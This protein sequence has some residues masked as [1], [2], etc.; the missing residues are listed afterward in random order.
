MYHVRRKER[1]IRDEAELRR[2]LRESRFVTLALCR[3]GEP[4]VVT[5]THGYDQE[6][7]CL[8]FHAA[9]DGQKLD[10]IRANPQ[11]CATAVEDHGYVVGDCSH[12]YRSVVLRG[13]VT[14]LEED[15]E[16]A[17]AMAV[18][19]RHHEEQPEPVER[20]FLSNPTWAAGVA[21]LRLDIREMTGKGN[22]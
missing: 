5:L 14:M 10:F 3:D 13:S 22:C 9:L 15:N 16:K 17:H 19:I 8:Y 1:E 18:L 7:D 12:K 20:R 6:R 2:I 21:M 4:Y 11:T